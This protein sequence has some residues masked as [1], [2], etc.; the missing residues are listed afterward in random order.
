MNE[1]TND[2]GHDNHDADVE[3]DVPRV[4]DVPELAENKP[5]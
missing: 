4:G 5:K 3:E 1:Q 2:V